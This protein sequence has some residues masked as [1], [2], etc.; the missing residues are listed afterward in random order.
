MKQTLASSGKEKAEEV[1]PQMTCELSKRDKLFIKHMLKAVD[2]LMAK[3]GYF[4]E[5]QLITTIDKKGKHFKK[6]EKELKFAQFEQ[7]A[8]DER[9]IISS[10]AN[11]ENREALNIPKKIK[12]NNKIYIYNK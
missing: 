6:A 5:K 12:C 3:Q 9:N 4:T 8:R 7:I 11:K 10:Y 1:F 2:E